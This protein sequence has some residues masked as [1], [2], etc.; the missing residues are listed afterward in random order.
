M[1]RFYNISQ[2]RWP[3][4]L[5]KAKKYV[6]ITWGS[7]LSFT[8]PQLIGV[9]GEKGGVTCQSTFGKSAPEVGVGAR[10]AVLRL[11]EGK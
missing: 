10:L 5:N 3:Q 7:R 2:C 9:E 4:E 11:L 8:Y 6:K 1:S